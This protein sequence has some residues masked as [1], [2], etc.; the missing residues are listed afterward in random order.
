MDRRDFVKISSLLTAGSTILTSCGKGLRETMPVLVPEDQL[1]LGEEKWVKSVCG[2]CGAACG[3]EVRLVD[4]R[5]VK[6]EG[7]AAHPINAGR[8]CARGQAELQALYNPD[9]IRAPRRGTQEADW[10]EALEAAAETLREAIAE[11][12]RIVLVTRRLNGLRAQLVAEFLRT[13]GGASHLIAEPLDEDAVLEANRLTC[14]YASHA[15]P[16]FG[17]ANYVLSFSAPLVEAGPSP[18]RTQRLLAHMRQGRPGR[19][20]KLVQAEARFSLTAA[21]ADEWLPLNPGTEGA[22]ALAIAHVLLRDSLVDQEFLSR[23]AQGLDRFRQIVAAYPPGAV[24]SNLGLDAGRIERVAREFAVHR[25]AVAVAGGSAAGHSNSL[26]ALVAINALNALV[27]SYGVPGGVWFGPAEP[28][29]PPPTLANGDGQALLSSARVVL[30]Y[31]A[32]PVYEFP[33]LPWDKVPFLIS[34]SAFPDETAERAH[35]VLPDHTA[36]ER[37]ESR[38]AGGGP[39]GV[40]RSVARPAL[41]LAP[42]FRTQD[43]ADTLLA[44]AARVGKPLPYENWENAVA[45]SFV[46]EEELSDAL[47][48]GGAWAKEPVPFAFATPSK[49]YEFVPRSEPAPESTEVP[50][51]FEAPRWVGEAGGLLLQVYAGVSLGTGEGANLPW[52]QELP[53]PLTQ[54]VWT[55]AAEL[56][57][58]TA[59]KLGVAHG[60][61]IWLESPR[62]KIQARA[63]VSPAVPPDAVVLAAGEG[64]TA[65]GRYARHRGANVFALLDPAAW[66]A[67]RVKVSKV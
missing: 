30:V 26:A 5:A 48:R 60:E 41:A 40:I 23:H 52:L 29:P 33:A 1:V 56:N 36:L 21:Y 47:E 9:R 16:D 67:T 51:G 3:L 53:D 27:G 19:R 34:L 38:E 59:R 6:L 55:T 31:G 44:L 42:P 57:A 61:R 43:A 37:W 25:P 58:T 8:L 28:V 50:P 24:A 20:G 54:A 11:P 13:L 22:L 17:D 62:G 45:A 32:N 49:K 14:G 10:E 2:G 12:Q 15:V 39:I 18:V 35:V 65:Y 64:H 66:A 46:S 4:G 7:L 63:A